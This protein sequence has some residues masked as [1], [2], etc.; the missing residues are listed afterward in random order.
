MNNSRKNIIKVTKA[1]F[2]V[3]DVPMRYRLIILE[4]FESENWDFYFN[5]DGLT[6]FNTSWSNEFHPVFVWHDY[7]IQNREYLRGSK[8]EKAY[9]R[10]TN[11]TLKKLMEIYNFNSFKTWLYP[12]LATISFKIF[13]R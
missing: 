11:L 6:F 2:K 10:D 13:K 12:I 3:F 4:A 8:N 5:S 9:I 1:S 7:A